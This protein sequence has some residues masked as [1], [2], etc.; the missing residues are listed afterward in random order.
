MYKNLFRHW[1]PVRLTRTIVF[2]PTA[3]S[4]S[5]FCP[6]IQ[7]LNL[8]FPLIWVYAFWPWKGSPHTVL[9]VSHIIWGLHFPHF[10]ILSGVA[11]YRIP[12]VPFGGKSVLG[13]YPYITSGHHR[14]WVPSYYP[15]ESYHRVDFRPFHK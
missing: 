3:L 6:H 12:E 14:I 11:K 8:F 13:A 5:S 1:K 15:K 7:K 4:R 10:E 9:L 2:V